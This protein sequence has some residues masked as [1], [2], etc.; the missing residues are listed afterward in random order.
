M[1]SSPNAY[2]FSWWR[3]ERDRLGRIQSASIQLV[4]GERD[5]LSHQSASQT[6]A[7]SLLRNLA[8]QFVCLL[9]DAEGDGRGRPRSPNSIAWIRL[10]RKKMARMPTCHRRSPRCGACASS[11]TATNRS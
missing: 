5:C 9:R 3:G 10:S 1:T 2:P 7:I 6:T 4:E 8:R 11:A